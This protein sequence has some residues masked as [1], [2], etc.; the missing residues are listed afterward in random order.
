[1]FIFPLYAT[2]IE[3][4][5]KFQH[6]GKEVINNESYCYDNSIKLLISSKPCG[7]K[8]ICQSKNLGTID[9]KMSEI[10]GETGSLGFKICEKFHGSPQIVEYWADNK[11]NPNSR[12]LFEDGSFID[13]A[14]LA[15][16]VKYVD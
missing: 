5:I 4:K 7:N 3:G 6:K 11:W 8:K 16:K 12:C 9:L 13:N 1:M 2:C 15:Q 10:A 14:S